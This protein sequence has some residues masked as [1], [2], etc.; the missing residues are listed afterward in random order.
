MTKVK[1]FLL[2]I[3]LNLVIPFVYLSAQE[4]IEYTKDIELKIL[5]QYDTYFV[6][7]LI[8]YSL[9]N[10]DL[11]KVYKYDETGRRSSITTY[12]FEDST[13][14]GKDR[15]T[16]R[17]GIKNKTFELKEEFS[18]GEWVIKDQQFWNYNSLQN[19]IYYL[20]E[21]RGSGS[22]TYTTRTVWTYDESDK[23]ISIIKYI[24]IPIINLLI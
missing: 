3:V 1:I 18:N 7:S 20:H 9:E 19:P 22:Y 8:V 13:W 5:N 15:F 16:Y 21:I 24:F 2:I 23:V 14:I 4:L 6:D 10:K 12:T 11:K 17:F